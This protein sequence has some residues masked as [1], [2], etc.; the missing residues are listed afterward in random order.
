GLLHHLLC[1]GLIA[2]PLDGLHRRADEFDSVGSAHI[3]KVRLFGKVAV[4]RMDGVH[5]GEDGSGQDVRDVQIRLS[6]R[7]GSYANRLI[8][9]AHVQAVPVGLR[10]DGNGFNAQFPATAQDAQRDFTTVRDKDSSEHGYS[11]SNTKR[12]CP[13]S[14]GSAFSTRIFT[15]RPLTSDSIS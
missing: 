15:T 1:H 8:G 5:L 11:F 9:Q 13:Y 7:P 2:H 4:S 3:G 12:G 14:T 10:I 6:R